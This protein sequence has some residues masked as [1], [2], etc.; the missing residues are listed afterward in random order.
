MLLI[1][2]SSALTR[3]LEPAAVLAAIIE[4]SDRLLPSDAHAIWRYHQPTNQWHIASSSGLSEDY[5]RG[6]IEVLKQ[7]PQMSARPIVADDVR[8]LPL[9]AE[10]QAAYAAEGIRSLLAMPLTIHDVVCGTLVFYYREPHH[11]DP[12]E[13]RV[14]TAVANLASSIIA[15]A[16]SCQQQAH[17][18]AESQQREERL[19]LALDAGRMGVW[20]WNIATN[21]VHWSKNL[22]PIHGLKEGEFEGT[23][24][25]FQR[26]VHPDDRERVDQAIADAVANCSSY[27]IEFRVSGSDGSIRWIAGKGQAF[28]QG[29]QAERLIGLGMDITERKRAERDTQFLADASASLAALVDYQTT[30]QKVAR[31]AVPNFAD[32][33]T[34]DML[35][36][37]GSLRRLA[38]EHV[39]PAKVEL[40]HE[41]YRK[42]PPEPNRPTGTWHIL[43]TGQAELTSEITD[44]LLVA[45]IREPELLSIIRELGLRSYIGVPL[46]V[47]DKVLGVITFISAES[48]RR[49]NEKD[50][51]LAE[52]LAH[53][54]A[55]AIENARLY[56]DIKLADRR[57]EEFLG[58]LAHELRNPLAPISTGLQ[59]LRLE[60]QEPEIVSMME[61]QVHHLVRLVDDLLDISRLMRNRVELRCEPL[62]LATVVRQAEETSRPVINGECHEL[63]TSLPTEP[64]YVDG[65]LVRLAQVVSNLLNNAA[66]YSNVGK[67]IWLTLSRSG[68]RGLI[69]VRDEGLGIAREMLPK[70]WDMF[71]QADDKT[72]QSQGGMGIGLTLVR[73]LVELHGGEVCARSDGL[74][75]GSEFVVSLPLLSNPPA[76]AATDERL[77]LADIRSRRVL[78]VDDNVDAA[79]ALSLVLRKSGHRV[80]VANDGASA[81]RLAQEQAPE[82]ALLD[83]GMPGMDGYELAGCF[84]QHPALRGVKLVAITGWGQQE[85]RARSQK[86]GFDAHRV[87]PIEPNE[88]ARLLAEL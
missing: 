55:I 84:K 32:W 49:Y 1:E 45:S 14:A 26:L 76:T 61:R 24:D 16:D 53:R 70:I 38:V 28:G 80:T 74:G 64:L 59:L 87:K 78:I 13:V 12:R 73:T 39:D 72:K 71:V 66:R 23:L 85:D 54:A 65:D 81:L 31:M 17:V 25:G 8:D 44:E 82:I 58:I 56:Q 46:A 40:A 19:Q 52:D 60:G 79:R 83:I 34:V 69:S 15:S 51:Q 20:D 22:G 41:V 3:T 33:C 48:G 77:Q 4:L 21:E 30:L 10:R 27:E 63:L 67:R 37:D 36:D 6:T 57:K 86:A 88:L 5:R 11:F 47:R 29:G 75:T 43:T 35:S 42:F 9:L 68:D 62:E 2:A 18:Q 50:L 7:T